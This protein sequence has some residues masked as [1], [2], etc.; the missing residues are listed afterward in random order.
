E[1]GDH[2]ERLVGHPAWSTVR[3]LAGSARIAL[4]PVMA[5]LRVLAFASL[6]SRALEGL[7]DAWR[8]LLVERVRQLEALDYSNVP[9]HAEDE[10]AALAI[11][12]ALPRL[13][14]LAISATGAEIATVLAGPV[15]QRLERFTARVR[16]RLNGPV[17]DEMAPLAIVMRD[18]PV[19]TLALVLHDW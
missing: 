7:V 14:R 4:H 15:A 16:G 1:A 5:S 9:R 12:R 3:E 19:A 6:T 18:A 2:V 17:A 11:C 13:R 10:L 8:D